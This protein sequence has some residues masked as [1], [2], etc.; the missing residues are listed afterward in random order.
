MHCT[1]N[2]V[3]NILDHSAISLYWI[4]LLHGAYSVCC[5]F[6]DYI[7]AQSQCNKHRFGI[8]LLKCARMSAESNK[9][10]LLLNKNLLYYICLLVRL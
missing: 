10:C 3:V 9:M 5:V 8:S 4:H 6:I 7:G 1:L 2:F